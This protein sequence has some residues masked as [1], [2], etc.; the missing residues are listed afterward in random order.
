MNN[1][2][3]VYQDYVVFVDSK[4]LRARSKKEYLRQVRK[5]AARHPKR[6]LKQITER[7]VFD[8]LI[9]LR[10]TEKLRPS[11]LNQAV[12][13][14]RMF[15]R[16]YLQ[17]NWKFWEQ[18]EIR[19]D[20]PL[21]VVLTRDEVRRVLGAVRANRFKAVLALIYHCCLRVGEAVRLRPQDIDSARGVVRVINGKGG[22]N[23]EVPIAPQMIKRLR[24]YW[25]CHR[26]PRWLFPG[27]GRGW[28][29]RSHTLAEAMG[30]ATEPM[31]VSS[32]QAALRMVV[33][34]SRDS[35]ERDHLPAMSLA[36][37]VPSPRATGAPLKLYSPAA[38]RDAAAIATTALIAIAIIMS[39]SR[40]GDQP[41]ELSALWLARTGTMG[42]PA[43]SPAFARAL[44]PD[45]PHRARS[46]APAFPAL[47]AR[48]LPA[49]L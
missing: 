17:R 3:K 44:F 15:F 4:S 6:S 37:R 16:D 41:P 2:S 10:D 40:R 14:L 38:P 31:S 49:L 22:K 32:V 39:I 27:V 8:H 30:A 34:A 26:N 7:M 1:T 28:R 24:R 5:L 35:Q 21:P 47:P 9:Y 33:P 19:R 45:H 43:G 18:F 48:T 12:V 25:R 42:S 46:A 13:A 36:P 20:Q 23:R 29:E 11:T